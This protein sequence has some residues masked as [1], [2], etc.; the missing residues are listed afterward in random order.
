MLE[1]RES[2][3]SSFDY[4]VICW[5]FDA[6]SV[7]GKNARRSSAKS[8]SARPKP[9]PS[10]SLHRYLSSGAAS[11]IPNPAPEPGS[12]ELPTDMTVLDP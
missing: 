12:P 11:S 4:H 8:L 2:N 5:A 6:H 10:S 3:V 7:E 1:G 9:N